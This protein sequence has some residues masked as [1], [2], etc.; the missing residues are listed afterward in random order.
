MKLL[1]IPIVFISLFISGCTSIKVTPLSSSHSIKRVAIK[2]NHRV[3]VPDFLNVVQ[4]GFEDH[5]ITTIVYQD[6]APTNCQATLTYTALRS[7]DLASYLSHAE[8]TL[9]DME[10]KRIAQATYHLNGKGGLDLSKWGSVQS[11]MEPV[12]DQLLSEYE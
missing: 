11:K 6:H 10:G 2:E 7:W 1:I 8:L 3:T 12:I 9:R 5:G 4:N